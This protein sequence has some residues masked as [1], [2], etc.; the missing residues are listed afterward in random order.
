MKQVSSLKLAPYNERI[1]RLWLATLPVT[2]STRQEND[3]LYK[4]KGKAYII[5]RMRYRFFYFD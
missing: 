2:L 3:V 5:W 1:I 4:A